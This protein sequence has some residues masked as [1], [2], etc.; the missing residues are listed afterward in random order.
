MTANHAHDIL[1]DIDKLAARIKDLEASRSV[2]FPQLIGSIPPLAGSAPTMRIP[3]P[4]GFTHLEGIYTA[5][6][7]VGGGGAFV[8]MRLNDDSAADYQWENVVG[9]VAQNSLSALVTFMQ[10]GLCA[11]AS[12]TAGYM[13]SGSF[14][15]GGASSTVTAKQV[16]SG[17]SLTCSTSTY[18]VAKHGGTWNQTAAVGAVTLLPDA[19]TFAPGSSLSIYGWR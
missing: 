16:S 6:K 2:G 5:R 11:G 4:P 8:Q 3:I 9:T 18:Y 13:A 15:I 17:S 19:G 1:D 14:T 12:D 10:I 7:S